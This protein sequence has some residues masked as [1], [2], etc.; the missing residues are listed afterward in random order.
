[1]GGLEWVDIGYGWGAGP[2]IMRLL[3]GGLFLP[4]ILYVLYLWRSQR[5][6]LHGGMIRN[7]GID[8]LTTFAP[9]LIALPALQRGMRERPLYPLWLPLLAG[10][11]VFTLLTYL[12]QRWAERLGRRRLPSSYKLSKTVDLSALA[13]LVL[14]GIADNQRW[15]IFFLGGPAYLWTLAPAP[16]GRWATG[17]RSALI[18]FPLVLVLKFYADLAFNEWSFFFSEGR[19][20]APTFLTRTGAFFVSGLIAIAW[21]LLRIG[22]YI[23]K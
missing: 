3:T 15:T 13:L 22:G 20:F 9:L 18:I 2:P 6:A 4:F 23:K 10:A 12:G 16:T 14:F 7:E 5:G 8:L 19:S 17:L 21:R 11:V 1:M